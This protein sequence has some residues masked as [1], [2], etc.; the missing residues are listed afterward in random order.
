MGTMKIVSAENTERG[1]KQVLVSKFELTEEMIEQFYREGY[2]YARGFITQEAVNAILEEHVSF[3]EESGTQEWK[4]KG[5]NNLEKARAEV[6]RTVSVLTDP[7][8]TRIFERILGG[9]VKFWLGMFA[10]VPPGGRG[11]EWHQDNQYTHILGHMLNAFIALDRITQENGGL[12]IAPRSHFG[13]QPNLN[14]DPNAHRRAPEP[15]N[16][17]P[18]EPLN[19]GDAIVF[20]RELLHHSKE[21]RTDKPRCAYAFQV[22]SAACR[23]GKTGKLLEDRELLSAYA[24]QS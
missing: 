2:F 21:N 12:W 10:V 17:V 13:L 19:P 3:A 14:P 23:Y 5:F 4:S 1:G 15:P 20:H 6:P 7:H 9:D 24:R 11:L 16:G 8:L 22:A 18:C